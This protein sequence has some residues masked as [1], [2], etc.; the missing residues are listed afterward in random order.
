MSVEGYA[1]NAPIIKV[2]KKNGKLQIGDSITSCYSWRAGDAPGTPYGSTV[3]ACHTC[4][5]TCS[6]GPG[7]GMANIRVGECASSFIG[8]KRTVWSVT[9]VMR[10][11]TTRKA[12]FWGG[13][14]RNIHRRSKM[15]W[16]TCSRPQS[17]G[18]YAAY[19]V[20][21]FHRGGC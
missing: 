12:S 16:Y 20:V 15:V 8:T 6:H 2:A 10:G 9:R 13:L 11:V 5:F 14:Y 1:V 3:V 19:T 4:H 17:D 21:V 18:H 7:N